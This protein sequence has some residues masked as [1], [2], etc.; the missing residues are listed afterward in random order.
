MHVSVSV[1]V[2]VFVSVFVSVLVSG[3]VA[4]TQVNEILECTS[5]TLVL[6]KHYPQARKS[7][8]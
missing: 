8:S 1:S 6:T 7:G 2:S 3:S 5:R 4:V